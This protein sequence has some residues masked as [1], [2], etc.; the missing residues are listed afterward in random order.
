[1]IIA[2]DF[3]GTI[4]EH[5]FP[6]IG[7]PIKGSISVL[8]KL[9]KE[10]H[11]LILWTC[12][13]NQDNSFNNRKLLTEAVV[14]CANKGL[15]FDAV[16]NNIEGL[17]FRPTPKIYYDVLIDDRNINSKIDWFEIYCYFFQTELEFD[18]YEEKY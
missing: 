15:I 18:C 7:L 6:E 16:N 10:G 4:V 8:K 3:D 1:M 9:K 14:W 5:R 17:G 11:K 13:N 12:R 2:V